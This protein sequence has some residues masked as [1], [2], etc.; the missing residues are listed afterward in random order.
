MPT[1]EELKAKGDRGSHDDFIDEML[2]FQHVE[3]FASFLE[4]VK[5]RRC[6]SVLEVGAMFGLSIYRIAQQLQPKST[7]VCVDLPLDP[8]V[9]NIPTE[10]VLRS[11]MET[12]SL[13]G[14]HAELFL[15]NS[16]DPVLIESVRKFAPFDFIFIDADHSEE[17]VRQDWANFGPMGKAV[18]FHDIIGEPGCAALWADIKKQHQTVEFTQSGWLGIGIALRE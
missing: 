15:G 16:H 10:P 7:V 8:P 18:G 14:H 5:S 11:N 6:K 12:I 3:E 1:V 9:N 2:L 17:A 4:F 13:M